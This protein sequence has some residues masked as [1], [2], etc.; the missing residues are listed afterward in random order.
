MGTILIISDM[1]TLNFEIYCFGKAGH[2]G[3]LSFLIF[4]KLPACEKKNRLNV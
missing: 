4:F 1:L 2:P 3:V